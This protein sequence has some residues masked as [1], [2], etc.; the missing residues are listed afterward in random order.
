MIKRLGKW[1][2]RMLICLDQLAGCWLRG[3]YFV[4]IGGEP[5][6]ADETISAWV[7]KSAAAGKRWALFAQAAIDRLFGA[8]HCQRAVAAD[9]RDWPQT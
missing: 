2:L 8:G 6:S 3:W 9:P 4:W 7:G 1:L 5:P